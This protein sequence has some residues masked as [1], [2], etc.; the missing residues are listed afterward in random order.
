MFVQFKISLRAQR[1]NREHGISFFAISIGPQYKALYEIKLRFA[2]LPYTLTVSPGHSSSKSYHPEGKV[3]L[4][5][6]NGE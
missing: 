1:R 3:I 4:T 6:K 5:A 2:L